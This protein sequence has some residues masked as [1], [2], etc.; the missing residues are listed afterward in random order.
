MLPKATSSPV[1]EWIMPA[2]NHTSRVTRQIWNWDSYIIHSYMYD[3]RWLS[4][5]SVNAQIAEESTM[6]VQYLM[7]KLIKQK[8]SKTHKVN[9]VLSQG[10]CK[11][12]LICWSTFNSPSWILNSKS[13]RRYRLANTLTNFRLIVIDCPFSQSINNFW[14]ILERLWNIFWYSKAAK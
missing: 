10:K 3:I 5:M 2:K 4:L 8:F 7:A 11:R 13:E 1:L 12:T 9:I 6:K 14:G